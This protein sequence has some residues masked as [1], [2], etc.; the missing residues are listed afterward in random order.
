MQKMQVGP[1]MHSGG[2]T[3]IE[4]AEVGS[5]YWSAR[6]LS[7]FDELR[8][9]VDSLGD[10]GGGRDQA[11]AGAHRRDQPVAA[12]VH[13]PARHAADGVGVVELRQQWGAR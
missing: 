13:G 12:R 7:H 2:N 6:R 8:G 9:S 4:K 11:G 1:R 10:V 5:A 3:A